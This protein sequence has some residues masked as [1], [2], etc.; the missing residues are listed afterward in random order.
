[1]DLEEMLRTLGLENISEESRA[2]FSRMTKTPSNCFLM[3]Y[4]LLCKQNCFLIK[5]RQN[6]IKLYNIKSTFSTLKGN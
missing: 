5:T 2:D 6:Y 4:W 3:F 1:M